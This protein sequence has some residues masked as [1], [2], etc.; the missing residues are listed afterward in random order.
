[1]CKLI[2]IINDL[3]QIVRQAVIIKRYKIRLRK[4][5]SAWAMSMSVSHTAI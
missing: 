5:S 1:M 3:V 4:W 2:I